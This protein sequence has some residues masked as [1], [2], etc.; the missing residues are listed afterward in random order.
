MLP[1]VTITSGFNS[2]AG[3]PIMPIQVTCQCGTRYTFKDEFAGSR[4]VCPTCK[5]QLVVPAH[6]TAEVEELGDE[7]APQ[8][9]GKGVL[10]FA[11]SATSA[12]IV[13]AVVLLIV[14]YSGGPAK[15]APVVAPTDDTLSAKVTPPSRPTLPSATSSQLGKATT[16]S[17]GNRP[18]S[19]GPKVSPAEFLVPFRNEGTNYYIL[20]GPTATEEEFKKMHDS[21]RAAHILSVG[22][23]IDWIGGGPDRAPTIAFIR[24]PF[25]KGRVLA[26]Y[27]KFTPG[28]ERETL[29]Y[30][31]EKAPKTARVVWLQYQDVGFA[32]N[33]VGEV[34][35][36]RVDDWPAKPTEPTP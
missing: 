31:D 9:S 33:E 5:R 3:R 35:A 15:P 8:K 21:F 29:T 13:L 16:A 19:A 24:K 27:D 1:G 18:A 10:I 28:E 22:D 2:F 20:L 34:M 23:W 6:V 14:H 4:T 17:A 12:V 30:G 7:E 36:I 26:T 25:P 32:V 11:I